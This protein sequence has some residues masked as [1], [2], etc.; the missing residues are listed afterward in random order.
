LWKVKD[1][2]REQVLDTGQ[3]SVREPIGPGGTGATV[4]ALGRALDQL[5]DAIA[6]DVRRARR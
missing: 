5:A 2:Q 1:G 3:T 4:E 6:G